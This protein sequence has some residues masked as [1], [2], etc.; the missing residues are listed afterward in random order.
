MR[1]KIYFD[2]SATTPV[3]PEV[4]RAM[5][6]YLQ[7][8][9]GNAS[10]AHSFGQEAM[11][12]VD[13]AREIIAEFLGAKPKEI[14]FTSGATESDNLVIQGVIKAVKDKHGDKKIH[15]I[16]SAIEH[17]AILEPCHELE[18]T[19][20][21]VTYLPVGS[22]G[23]VSVEEV[24]KSITEET[25]L[26]SIMYVN[27]EVG[28]IQPISEIGDLVK[29]ARTK[30]AQAD[31]TMPLI[32]H[33]DA[34][35]AI[36]YCNCKVNELGVDLMSI[37]GHKIYGPK[38]IGALY[39]REGTP[40]RPI[41]I[42][43]HQERGIRSG[44]LNTIGIVGLG[45]AIEL[46]SRKQSSIAELRRIRELRD[47]LIASILKIIPESHVNGDLEKRVPSNAHFSFTNV[48][49]ESILLMLDL[50]GIAVSTGSACA[51]GSLAPS[52]VLMAMGIPEEV[53]HGSLRVTLGRFTTEKE[54]DTLLEVLP[55]IIKK[56]RGMSPIK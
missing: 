5:M 1:N 56:L 23:L 12:G 9:F 44:T 22:D 6:P 20:V 46:V 19:G 18:K 15:I 33:T 35:Q 24:Q 25:V 32:F 13:S 28:T 49:G 53:A 41:Q 42:G 38:G 54:I 11:K 50:E 37:S 21:K 55:S 3:D 27:N 10:S 2:H 17:P 16:T 43:G 40:I 14:I 30:R 51:S 39:A 31:N 4:L 8:N 36:N 29:I 26:I 52:H 48:E 45:K 7:D 34:V 47:K